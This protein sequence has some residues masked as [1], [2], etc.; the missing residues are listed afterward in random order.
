MFFKKVR[1]L[2]NGTMRQGFVFKFMDTYLVLIEIWNTFGIND[3]INKHYIEYKTSLQEWWP[4]LKVEV[5]L[6]YFVGPD[7]YT[8]VYTIMITFQINR[9]N[10]INV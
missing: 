7:K 8:A 6:C 2:D 1:K 5:L 10:Q 3:Q 4:I 9:S